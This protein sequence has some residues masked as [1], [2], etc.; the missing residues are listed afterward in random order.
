M[1]KVSLIIIV[2]FITVL[3]FG[4]ISFA[5]EITIPP[6]PESLD[7]EYKYLYNSAAGLVLAVSDSQFYVSNDLN[8]YAGNSTVL[9]HMPIDGYPNV[10][11]LSPNTSRSSAVLKVKQS[12]WSNF[13]V[14]YNDN[15]DVFFYNPI[16]PIYILDNQ[17]LLQPLFQ[18]VTQNSQ[19]LLV[20]GV[21]ILS[22]ILSVGLFRKLY[23]YL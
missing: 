17:T 20:C 12:M 22:L 1:N 2:V 4:V 6:I 3:S 18:S 5:D 16:V 21:G 8:I 19:I 11:L 15:S 7:K 23:L 14:K 9:V 13:D 10:E